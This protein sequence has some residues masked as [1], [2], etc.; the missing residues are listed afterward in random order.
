[1]REKRKNYLKQSLT[2]VLIALI[3]VMSIAG[4]SASATA[5]IASGKITVKDISDIA[6]SVVGDYALTS[7]VK[8]GL[9]DDDLCWAVVK[10][11]TSSV[12][13]KALNKNSRNI[14][15]YINSEAAERQA[16]EL[17]AY[18]NRFAE[19]Y[20]DVILDRSY[21][22]TTLL[23]GIA[24]QLY[25]RDVAV[26]EDDPSVE[27]VIIS[28]RYNAPKAITQNEVNIYP[29]GIYNPGNLGYD[30][31]GT[32]VAVLDTGLDYTHSAFANQPTG[33]AVTK[34]KVSSLL[35][36][37]EATKMSEKAEAVLTADSLYVSDKV[38]FAYDYADS[39]ADV[40]PVNNHGTHVAGIIAGQDDVITGIA[41]NA[42]LA[43]MKVFSNYEEGASSEAILA[44]LNDCVV[45]GVD[46]INM[47]L[48]SSCGFSREVDEQATNE[49]YD[50]I[51]QTGICLIAAASNDS[52]SAMQSTN[53]DTNLTGNPDSGTVGS[54]SSYEASMSVA[55]I[56]GVKTKYFVVNG[57]QEVYF[58]E[59]SHG[60]TERNDFVGEML[61][62][63]PSGEFE[64]V[65][66]PGLGQNSNYYDL[67]VRGK[68]AVVKR[69]TSSFEE[70]VT[71]AISYGAAG[72]II[73]N[74]VSGTISMTIGKAE[75]PAC[76]ISMDFGKYF[77]EHPTG[78]LKLDETYLAGPFMSDFSS[79]GPLPDLE[80]KPDITAHGGD[81]YSAVRGGYDY[82]SGTSMAA[83]NMAGATI[84]VR[85]Y[86]K[87]RFPE[88]SAYEVTEMTYQLIMST[89][90]IAYNEEGNPYSPR[91]QG[92]GLADIGK[93]VNTKAFIYVKGENKTKLTLGDDPAKKGEYTLTFTV[94]NLDSAALSYDINPIVFT[95][96][97]SSDNKTVAQKA[98]MLGD[99]SFTA[100]VSGEGGVISG[101]TLIL[102]GYS[103]ADVTVKISLSDDAKAYLD[104]TFANGMYV[105]GFVQLVSSNA[106]AINLNIPYL[107]FYGDWSV[108]PMLD[109][110]AYEVGEQQE[111]SSILEEDKL[112]ED[113]Y[114]TLPM[115][116]FRYQISATEYEESFYGMGQ[117]AY[118]LADGYSEPAILEDKASLTANMDGSFSLK[119][120]AAGLLR[121]AKSVYMEITDSV[122]GELIWSATDY[123]CRKS[124][125]S[126]GRRPGIVNV[127]FKVNDYNLA[128]NSKYKFTMECELD[129]TTTEKN[130]NNS[131]EFEFYIDN[132]APVL[133]EDRTQVRVETT[134][135]VRRYLLD[136]YVYDNH[137][138]QGYAIGTFS[139]LAADGTLN[140][141]YAFHNYVI[142]LEDGR[143][144]SVNRITYDIT[145]YWNQ[146]MANGGNIYLQVLDYAKNSTI[147]NLVLPSSS[148]VEIGFKSTKQNVNIEANTVED[149]KDFLVTSPS[150]LWVKDLIWSVDDET[151]AIIRDG[152]ILGLT[153]GE[154][155]LR[156]SNKDGTAEAT[157]PVRIRNAR[158][159]TIRLN[160]IELDK[161][162]WTVERGE[163]FTVSATLVPHDLFKGIVPDEMFADVNLVWRTD[164]VL[165]FVTHDE[166]GDEVLTTSV[167]GV[168]EVTVRAI[169]SGGGVN[170]ASGTVGVQA[171]N[172]S[173]VSGA[174]SVSVKSE[175]KTEG[176]ILTNYVGR[177]DENGV[178][179]I[180]DDLNIT[181]IYQYAFMNNP[182]ITKI[183]V[184]EGVEEIMEAAIYGCDSLKEVV[185]PQSCKKID[186][187]GVAWNS[188][189]E[190]VDLGG[191]DTIDDMAF[192][193]SKSLK[194]IDLSGV[195]LIGPRA[196]A[197][198][199][200]LTEIDISSVKSM[201]QLAFAF[202]SG[203]TSVHTGDETPIGPYAFYDCYNLVEI[204]LNGN[205]VGP[206]A[207]AFCA[208]LQ[209][210]T[211]NNAVDTIDTGAFYNCKTL[212]EVNYRSTLRVIG[213]AAFVN[214][215]FDS[216]YLPAG[217]EKIGDQA[218][219]F[220]DL[221]SAAYGGTSR[222]VI[223]AGA[224][225]T[226]IG[227]S[228]FHACKN[229]SEF[230]VEEG[231]A[232]LS[233]SGGVLYDKAQKTVL[234]CPYGFAN[235]TLDL[236][237]SVTAIGKN[238]FANISSVRTITGQNV[239]RVNDAAFMGASVSSITFSD[240]LYY[241]GDAA[242]YGAKL[243]TS[244][245]ACFANVEYIGKQAFQGSGITGKLTLP[246][247]LT[248]IGERSF[249][250]TALSEIVIGS[251]ITEIPDFAFTQCTNL[252]TFTFGENVKKIGDYGFAYCSALQ[253]VIMPDSL[254]EVGFGAFGGCSALATVRL[255]E[256]L[257][258]L[259]DYIF[260]NC[261][262]LKSVTL[263]E[264]VKT[265]GIC[266]FALADD[267]TGVIG[268]GVLNEINLENVESIA[269]Y[270]FVNTPMRS[271]DAPNLRFVGY[272][273]FA[274]SKTLSSV[275]LPALEE[276]GVQ[277]FYNC[278]ALETAEI[279]SAKTIGDSAFYG[280]TSLTS[281]DLSGAE[282]IGNLA[283]YGASRLETITFGNLQTLGTGALAGTAVTA[284]HLP[285]SVNN[286]EI[287]ALYGARNLK[288][289]TV[290]EDNTTYF[291]EN[292]VLY[293]YLPNGF[294]ALECYPAALE[295]ESYTA[296]DA[297]IRVE[298]YAFAGNTVVKQIVIPER[299]KVLGAGAFYGCSSLENLELRSAAAPVLETIYDAELGIE[300]HYYNNFQNTSAEGTE[301]NIVYPQNG[302]GYD[303]YI[304]QLY[305]KENLKNV[306]SVSRTQT[307]IDMSDNLT[308]MTTDALTLADIDQIVLMRRI[309]S[310]LDAAQQQFLAGVIVKLAAA[311]DKIAALVGAVIDALPSDI[312]LADKTAVEQARE[313][314]NMLN[315]TMQEKV[316]N[317]AKL[318][319]AE[320]KIAELSSGEEPPVNPGTPSWVLPV[321]ICVPAVLLA[322]AAAAFL[323]IRKKRLAAAKDNGSEGTKEDDH[324]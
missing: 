110:D 216:V 96:S 196:F 9:S 171:D 176:V 305:F 321:A 204:E 108:A 308:A 241:I 129:W 243:L 142:P 280:C 270:A 119:V 7:D 63:A 132:E 285:Y 59:S 248:F 95:E 89:A 261:P 179:E 210:V 164:G 182:Y 235:R 167:S 40:Y 116:G 288:D 56:S 19:R 233:S 15:E 62:G 219:S 198:C 105:E 286:L 289:I 140:D 18:Q 169:R 104:S 61:N 175:Y 287:Q 76:S 185:L 213:S 200:S 125:Y 264:S 144:N 81:I 221:Y 174:C 265:I 307:T 177:G 39:D 218:Y 103:E 296:L 277:A 92:A 181:M 290:D 254:T 275:N 246:S 301:I 192:V 222:V 190:K 50:L 194:D 239:V 255:S 5:G 310:S 208:G 90:T 291:V 14:Y 155:T 141:K 32:V 47:S 37:F 94:R 271:V 72:V 49:I 209:T 123:N 138:I 70:K 20:S 165:R 214:C 134:G 206:F 260:Y 154:T 249:A 184:P 118:K 215:A 220:D 253:S 29:T 13:E 113:V 67:D 78:S 272:R 211:F 107:A 316:T 238:A 269:D 21:S 172:S 60:G 252:K 22:Y 68:I 314:Y 109:A 317:L 266:A 153:A 43:I 120:I 212:K 195:S 320:Q 73:Y 44:A 54:P 276:V 304:W 80:L 227:S 91:K 274:G 157:L 267:S 83:P 143:R 186:K 99:T 23:N 112:K 66:V 197:Y 319:A 284:V 77:E 188:A 313:N 202:C 189:L 82:Y 2:L 87:E 311:E 55:S 300:N 199:E 150:N 17:T 258:A 297:T 33:I 278:T 229:L 41:T 151:V 173:Y 170:G 223:S 48:G 122:T 230:V 240:G 31:T 28:E 207:F 97:L 34:D 100:S 250:E 58:T 127:E 128:N 193:M 8:G 53:G 147:F 24:V 85:E 295:G 259:S 25:Y 16:E 245:P 35:S 46:A 86:V 148:A 126:G 263:P 133:V 45:L 281:L 152:V 205:Y 322:A 4:V 256:N 136:M 117:F 69:G 224:K 124:Y 52:S 42:Q 111:N 247:S 237:A 38:P 6:N 71:T 251:G 93:S 303:G 161:N 293:R 292:G 262:S 30:G 231:N 299:V 160:K 180:P 178:V 27:S 74:N 75:A 101:K 309:Y 282:E 168:K 203:L 242:F 102:A 159:D 236:P 106:D 84:L 232:Y 158:Y 166:N 318:S 145:N 36:S 225:L 146:I 217:L 137:Y 183:I 98:Y 201:D 191:V 135:G 234:L 3:A 298:A 312:T 115:G 163:D 131:Y 228:V 10:F 88:L 11:H 26:L 149:L 65:V 114:A 244:W 12:L 156:V 294:F 273:A 279:S 1:M 226:D 121:N 139:S 79:W 283:M 64:Y 57:E 306:G 323:I 268:A 162:A 315:A 130:L 324:E 187:W 257:D 51:K 302:S